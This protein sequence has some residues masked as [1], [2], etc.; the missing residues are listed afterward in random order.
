[1]LFFQHD[2]ETENLDVLTDQ[3]LKG[4]RLSNFVIERNWEL[5]EN[6][7]SNRLNFGM[8]TKTQEM[9]ENQQQ[10]QQHNEEGDEEESFEPKSKHIRFN[11]D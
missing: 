9:S 8:K 3:K 10:Q 6:L 1:M 7:R 2:D 4:E 5:I 11:N